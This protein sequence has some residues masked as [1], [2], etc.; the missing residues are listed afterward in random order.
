MKS[1]YSL[2][3]SAGKSARRACPDPENSA[4]GEGGPGNVLFLF[5]FSHQHVSQGAVRP[6]SRC[7]IASQGGTY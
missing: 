6:T 7:H 2:T 5:F 1:V 3:L 4:A